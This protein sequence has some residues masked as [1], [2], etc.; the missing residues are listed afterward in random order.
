MKLCEQTHQRDNFDLNVFFSSIRSFCHCEECFYQFFA[1]FLEGDEQK[2][3]NIDK[4]LKY[5]VKK[6]QGRFAQFIAK[7]IKS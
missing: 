1:R 6:T 5:D 3:Q 7:K 2:A 4:E